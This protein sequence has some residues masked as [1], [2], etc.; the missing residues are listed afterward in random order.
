[1]EGVAGGRHEGVF[2]GTTRQIDGKLVGKRS[3]M[4]NMTWTSISRASGTIYKILFWSK[5]S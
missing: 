5:C 3:M 2:D 1:M 4:Y